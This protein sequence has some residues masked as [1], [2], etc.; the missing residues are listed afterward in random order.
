M[1]SA[2]L[3]QFARRAHG[4]T[5]TDQFGCFG[6]ELVRI[7]AHGISFRGYVLLSGLPVNVESCLLRA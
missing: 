1:G 6:L 5:P 3:E 2:A 7:V 4:R